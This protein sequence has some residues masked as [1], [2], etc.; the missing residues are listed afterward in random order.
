MFSRSYVNMVNS[1]V[2]QGGYKIIFGKGTKLTVFSSKFSVLTNITL[3]HYFKICTFYDDHQNNNYC[4][5]L[6]S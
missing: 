3:K 4:F 5:V 6:E 2:T 1:C